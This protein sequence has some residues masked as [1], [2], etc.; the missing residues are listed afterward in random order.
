MKILLLED[1]VIL[2]ELIKEFLENEFYTVNHFFSGEDAHEELFTNKYDLL[3]LDINVPNTNGL[4]I[5]QNFRSNGFTTPV[6]LMTASTEFN[7]FEKAYLL[8][9]NDFIRKPFRLEELKIRIE[10]LKKMF[11]LDSSKYLYINK[12]LYFDQL[13]K[14]LIKNNKTIKL[15]KKEAEIIQYF[16]LHK[17]RVISTN[18]LVINIWAYSTEPSIATIRT[19]IKNIRKALDYNYIET[20]KGIGYIF[21]N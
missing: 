4:E 11:L 5:L 18:E 7:N 16:L 20:I 9:T 6:I 3:L 19:Y 1:D 13:N 10:Y 17:N 14:C 15:P 2:A 12:S 21:K 8:G